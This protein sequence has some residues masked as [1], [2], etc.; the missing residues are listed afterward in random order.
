MAEEEIVIF[1]QLIF[2]EWTVK[3]P[4]RF[5][6]ADSRAVCPR[7]IYEEPHAVIGSFAADNG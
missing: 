5:D 7:A 6:A 4:H 2:S 1:M 3:G